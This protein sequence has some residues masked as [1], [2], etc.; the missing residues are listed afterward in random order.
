M[1]EVHPT[2]VAI[3]GGSGAGKTALARAL[4]E[5]LG[6]DTC[7]LIGQDDYYHDIRRYGDNPDK[8]NFD[9]PA[10]IDF[11]L[12]S[13]HLRELKSGMTIAKPQYDYKTHCR[14]ADSVQVSP[15][16]VIIVEG[17]LVL[18]DPSMPDLFDHTC[19]IACGEDIRLARRLE[20]DVRERGR[21]QD[22]VMRRL[23]THVVPYHNRYVRR[24][25]ETVDV[26]IKQQDLVDNFGAVVN[27][28]VRDWQP[29]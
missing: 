6:D 11:G 29:K 1:G 9:V 15:K 22:E 17:I 8:I 24:L 28:L 12:L 21:E 2:L 14:S 10:S 5:R 3:T 13:Q 25:R 16:P 23:K 18:A 27:R 20:R 19:Y 4:G 26:V 7:V